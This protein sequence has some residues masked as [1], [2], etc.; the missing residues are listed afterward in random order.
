MKI[1]NVRIKEFRRFHDLQIST[2]PP[3]K[4][5]VIAGPNGSGKSSLFDAFSVWQQAH[6]SSLSWDA[7]YYRRDL[8]EGGWNEQVKIDF[9]SPSAGKKSF[10]LRSAYRNDPEFSLTSLNKLSEPT[11][12]LRVRRMIDQDGAVSDNFHRLASNALQDAF[13]RHDE[14]TTLK[15]FR[16]AAVGDV[17]AAVKRLFPDLDLSTLGNPLV[18]GTFRFTKGLAKGFSYKNLSGG[19]KAAFDLMLDMVVKARTYDDTVY[20]IDEPELHMNTRLQGALLAELYKLIPVACQLWIATHSIGMMRKARE[21]YEEYPGDVI[22]LDFDGRDFDKPVVITPSVPNRAFWE[23]I[24]R[25]ALDD[26]AELIA[27]KQLFICE[28]DPKSLSAAG[29]NEEHDAR[30]YGAIFEGEFPD[31]K[32]ISGGNSKDVSK[33]RMQFAAAFPNVVQGL[34]VHRLIDRDDHS[35]ADVAEFEKRGIRVLG[36]RHIE[37]FL[38]DDEVLAALCAQEGQPKAIKQVIAAKKAAIAASVSRGNPA[39]DVKSAAGEIYTCLRRKLKITQRGN[40]PASFARAVLV[41]LIKP[42]MAVYNELRDSIFRP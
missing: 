34:V 7:A 3:A 27:P 31:T 24:L 25:V 8:T 17:G 13:E 20:A 23:R 39:D 29:K 5:I 10:Y 36:R 33:D 11:E 15:E 19:E 1:K 9:Y 28:G 35:D 21:L 12:H 37:S 42:G 16:K 38:Y 4:L 30:C 14:K 40:D 26:L 22:F 18:D 32:F 6:H 41:P 2:L